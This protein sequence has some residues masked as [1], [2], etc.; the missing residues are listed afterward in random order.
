MLARA[1]LSLRSFRL[2]H[3]CSSIVIVPSYCVSQV[4]LY[5]FYKNIALVLSLFLFNFYNGFSGTTL[6]ESFVQAGWNFFLALPIIA[7]GFQD[8]DVSVCPGSQQASSWCFG[9]DDVVCCDWLQLAF[10]DL[11]HWHLALVV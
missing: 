7:I 9:T 1:M 2:S 6:F 4:I 5:S 11:L 10:L 8:S 3:V